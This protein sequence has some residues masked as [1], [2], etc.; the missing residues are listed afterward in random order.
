MYMSAEDL[1]LANE[2]IDRFEANIIVG[3]ELARGSTSLAG[4]GRPVLDRLLELPHPWCGP[5][6]RMVAHAAVVQ[7]LTW[8]GGSG[9]RCDQPTAFCAVKGSSGHALHDANEPLNPSR[10][11]VYR[12]GRSFCEAVTVAWQLRDVTDTDGG[13]ACV[14]GSH[15]AQ[16]RMPHGVRT[17]D[18][19]MGLVVHPTFAAG[20][21]M[22]FMDG[23]QTHGALAWQSDLA[24]RSVLIK[25]S[26]RSFNRSGGAL[27]HP[28]ARWG[29]V[30]KGM[31]DAQLAV[32]R[33]PDRDNHGGNVPRLELDD[34]GA[35][36][37][38][39]ERSGG[40]YSAATPDRPLVKA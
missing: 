15:K 26:S 24:R 10:S 12:N 19:D 32:M 35:V 39:Y 18:A 13:F 34:A 20:D 14:P 28:E 17:C 38:C 2:A 16:Y 3:E 11:Y 30:V 31:T 37:V 21:V 23:A 9:F 7:R 1:A 4:T 36:A 25:Y 8:M 6:R 22:F 29:D 33:G 5:F 40:L 27:T